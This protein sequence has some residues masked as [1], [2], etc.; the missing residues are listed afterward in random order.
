[1]LGK[2]STTHNCQHQPPPSTTGTLQHMHFG[3]S[4]RCMVKNRY[5]E[6]FPTAMPSKLMQKN[7]LML[8]TTL[9]SNT[10]SA[11]VCCDTAT[12]VITLGPSLGAFCSRSALHLPPL[13]ADGCLLHLGQQGPVVHILALQQQQQ[14]ATP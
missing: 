6:G 4:Q 10:K 2:P 14:P 9:F 12:G 8:Q 11:L 5:G 7:Q 13:S 3:F 1:M